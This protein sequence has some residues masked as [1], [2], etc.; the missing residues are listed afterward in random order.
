MTATFHPNRSRGPV[1]AVEDITLS[2][3]VS[4]PMEGRAIM[5]HAFRV[6]WVRKSASTMRLVHGGHEIDSAFSTYVDVSAFDS[7]ASAIE[8]IFLPFVRRHQVGAQSTLRAEVITSISD[9]PW[10]P[11]DDPVVARLYSAQDALQWALQDLARSRAAGL[12]IY[13]SIPDEWR[14]KRPNEY[15]HEDGQQPYVLQRME[16]RDVAQ[17]VVW[18][19]GMEEELDLDSVRASLIAEFGTPEWGG[20]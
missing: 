12:E 10:L 5:D 13:A 3:W 7:F 19:S 4:H 17:R 8:N 16:A 6:H 18:D 2:S 11:I 15:A 14:V 20:A 1:V 9:H